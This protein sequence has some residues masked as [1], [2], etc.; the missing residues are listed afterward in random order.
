MDHGEALG[1][2]LAQHDEAAL[3]DVYALYGPSVLSFLQR[4][5][6]PDEAEDVLQRT[7]FD[8]WRHAARYDSTQRFSTWLFTIAHRRAVDTLRARRHPVV[9][10]A[11]LRDLVGEDGRDTVSQLADAADVQA[12]LRELPEHEREVLLLAYYD[13]LTQREIAERLAVPIGTV[14]ARAARG[15]KHLAG[16]MRETGGVR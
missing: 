5:V 14:K 12:A 1:A 4:H 11:S 2:R 16:A 3:E 15:T 8:V 7:F 13:G 10:V 6:G 9:D